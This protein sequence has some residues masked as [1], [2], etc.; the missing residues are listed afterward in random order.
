[1]RAL[2]FNEVTSLAAFVEVAMC[3][4]TRANVTVDGLYRRLSLNC[5]Y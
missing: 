4:V 5:P 3:G 1:M 2:N